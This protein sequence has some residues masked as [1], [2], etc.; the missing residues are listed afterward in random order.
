M[1]GASGIEPPTPSASRKCSSP[2][3]RTY[4]L[5][6]ITD[7]SRSRRHSVKQKTSNQLTVFSWLLVLSLCYPVGTPSHQPGLCIGF[8]DTVTQ[9]PRG[10][11]ACNKRPRRR[12]HGSTPKN[13]RQHNTVNAGDGRHSIRH[14]M[15]DLSY[16]AWRW[17]LDSTLNGFFEGLAR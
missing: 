15:H 11:Q 7:K 6:I 3:L 13:P 12:T 1:V 17:Q 10:T 2:E 4:E 5:G 14:L 8:R 16:D 9:A